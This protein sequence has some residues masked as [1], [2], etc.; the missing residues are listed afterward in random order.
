MNNIVFFHIGQQEYV[1][2]AIRQIKF[3]NPDSPIYFIGENIDERI[4]KYVK[5]YSYKDLL[6]KQSFNFLSKFQNYSS[7]N[8][9]FEKICILRWFC[10]R[11]LCIQE[12]LDKI[13][14]SDCDIM[15]YCSIKE[16]AKKFEKYF[17]SIAA[18]TSAQLKSSLS[19]KGG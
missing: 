8:S 17:F 19:W 7:N 14:Y 1:Y 12:S 6:C 10:I 2:E 18:K 9:D 5:F 16:E 11:N 13:F 4:Y 3:Y 15:F